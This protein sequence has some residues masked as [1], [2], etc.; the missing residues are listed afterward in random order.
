M[1]MSI[2]QSEHPLLPPQQGRM[3]AQFEDDPLRNL[4]M[5][6]H[7]LTDCYTLL[8]NRHLLD[9]EELLYGLRAKTQAD[10]IVYRNIGANLAKRVTLEEEKRFIRSFY[11]GPLQ[12]LSSFSLALE[13]CLMLLARTELDLLESELSE[14][15]ETLRDNIAACYQWVKEWQIE[16]NH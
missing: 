13:F 2:P 4:V 16:A 11:D 6:N 7:A 9:L 12:V 5:S 10:L 1:I 14:L 3:T 8:E 15:Q